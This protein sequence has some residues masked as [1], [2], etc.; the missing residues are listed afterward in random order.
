MDL[1]LPSNA[2]SARLRAAFEGSHADGSR[3]ARSGFDLQNQSFD[4]KGRR[5]RD[6]HGGRGSGDELSE[7]V[8]A[9]K[10]VSNATGARNHADKGDGVPKVG[11]SVSIYCHLHVN[12]ARCDRALSNTSGS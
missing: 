9:S 6:V 2:M 1:D 7:D 4:G 12:G 5:G 3:T 8:R 11:V 10:G